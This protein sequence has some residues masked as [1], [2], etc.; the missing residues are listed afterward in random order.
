MPMW[1]TTFSTCHAL[2]N[3]SL[4]NNILRQVFDL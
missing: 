1:H 3:N 2:L 4:Q